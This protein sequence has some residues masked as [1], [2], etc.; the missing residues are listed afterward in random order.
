[1][2]CADTLACSVANVFEGELMTAEAR[3]VVPRPIVAV[4]AALVAALLVAALVLAILAFGRRNSGLEQ[5]TKDEQRA[6][7]A[8]RQQVINIQ[9]F[10]R[11]TFE[12]D[13]AAALNGMTEDRKKEFA[14]GKQRLLD[15]LNAAKADGGADVNGAGLV[16]FNKD[17][18]VVLVSSDAHRTDDKGAVQPLGGSRFQLTMKLTN[19][20]WLMSDLQAVTIG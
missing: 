9:T 6:L 2:A 10:R 3:R 17:T 16:S 7:N 12:A 13:F 11:K 1:V 8:A 18:A 4:L 14:A 15:G 5:L 20:K 19:G